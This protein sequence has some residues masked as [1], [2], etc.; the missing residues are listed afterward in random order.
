M[1]KKICRINGGE[2]EFEFDFFG[3]RASY[4]EARGIYEPIIR[5]Q[6]NLAEEN[7]FV[8]NL[9][10]L[11]GKKITS[12]ELINPETERTVKLSPV[13]DMI[14]DVST[15]FPQFDMQYYRGHVAF[16][17]SQYSIEVSKQ[18]IDEE[19]EAST[20]LGMAAAQEAQEAIDLE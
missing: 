9:M 14:L 15:D 19:N 4:N 20:N 8:F 6:T 1:A 17:S 18:L 7:D 16:G 12:L 11:M 3:E 10:P 5:F 13:Y 2:F